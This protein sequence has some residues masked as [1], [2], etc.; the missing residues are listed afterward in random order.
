MPTVAKSPAPMILPNVSMSQ[1]SVIGAA[2][3]GGFILYLMLQGKLGAY[4]SLLMGGSNAASAAPPTTT[5]TT[6][7]PATP[8]A[9]VD[10]STGQS[11]TLNPNP[12]YLIAPNPSIGF[13]GLTNP[14]YVPPATTT[15][16]SASPA[17]AT[18][19]T[20]AGQ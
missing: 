5:G 2:L 20:G 7:G 13:P 10:P 15:A 17:P 8:G 16:P 18:P 4:W 11:T 3:I 9:Y 12:G 19:K 14:F 1:S 6:Q